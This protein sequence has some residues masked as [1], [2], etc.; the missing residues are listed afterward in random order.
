M[1]AHPILK[2]GFVGLSMAGLQ[3]PRETFDQNV[4]AILQ[5]TRLIPDSSFFYH[6]GINKLFLQMLKEAHS[7]QILN[8]LDYQ[9]KILKAAAEAFGTTHF[10]E[11]IDF[12]AGKPT[13]SGIHEEFILETLRYLS[14]QP[15]RIAVQQWVRLLE[16]GVTRESRETLV[17]STY[18]KDLADYRRMTSATNRLHDVFT[19]WIRRDGGWYDFVCSMA[20]IF[21]NRRVLNQTV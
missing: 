14:G 9:E 5:K 7:Y 15:R 3:E 8:N 4:A 16:A 11:W 20:A 6:E 2:S 1:D 18:L 17:E 21:A 13:I 19:A 10:W 12:Q